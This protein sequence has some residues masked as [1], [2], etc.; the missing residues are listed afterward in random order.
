MSDPYQ[1]L[2]ISR[3][4]SDEEIKKAYRKLSRQ[5]HPDANINNP[6][7]AQAEEKF[8]EVQQAYNQIMKEKE[9]GTSDSSYQG[10]GSYSSGYGQGRSYDNSDPFG[11]FY[12]GF[13]GNPFGGQQS[14]GGYQNQS[15]QNS[16]SSEDDIKMRAA[17]NYLNNRA[18]QEA[19]NTLNSI[20]DRTAQWYYYCSIAHSGLGN[21]VN[22]LNYAR[23]ASSMD[24]DNIEYQNLIHRLEHGGQWY[25]DMSSGFGGHAHVN[26]NNLCCYCCMVQLCCNSCGRGFY[27]CLPPI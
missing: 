6:N 2:G 22:A 27:C 14:Y 20:Q 4:A 9:Q 1:V 5:Y 11:G 10:Q 23:R 7:A 15:Y 21:N 16:Y 24:P 17:A 12:G 8:K 25:D 3:S 19:L 26:M 18:Y 13:Y